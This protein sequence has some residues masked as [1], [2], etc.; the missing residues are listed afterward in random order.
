MQ[1]FLASPTMARLMLTY[2]RRS[3]VFVVL[4]PVVRPSTL[5]GLL[6][7]RLERPPI[8]K[9]LAESTAT[10]SANRLIIPDS[11]RAAARIAS[12]VGPLVAT[13]LLP[14]A[15]IGLFRVASNARMLPELRVFKLFCVRTGFGIVRTTIIIWGDLGPLIPLPNQFSSPITRRNLADTEVDLSRQ[16]L[17]RIALLRRG[18]RQDLLFLTS[19]YVLFV[20]ICAQGFVVRQSFGS[21]WFFRLTLY[22]VVL[23]VLGGDGIA[24]LLTTLST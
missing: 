3:I 5:F 1:A 13:L 19:A 15:L 21:R 20:S 2:G 22:S 11:T 8:L 7:S 23:Y 17:P 12:R 24:D 10:Y 4:L 14:V 18:E 16:D 6:V 9:G